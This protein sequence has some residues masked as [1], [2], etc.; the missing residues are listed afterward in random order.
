MY[1][2]S[3]LLATKTRLPRIA[4]E[5][6][7]RPRL[8]QRLSAALQGKLTLIVA[9]AGF[10]K[11]TL[12]AA[13]LKRTLATDVPMRS[14]WVSLDPGDDQPEQFWAYVFNA[15]EHVVPGCTDG[16]ADALRAPSQPPLEF[17]LT[18]LLNVLLNE[19]RPL[20]LVLDDFHVV[21]N[22]AVLRSVVFLLDHL[23][24]SMHVLLLSRHEPD[25]P[26]AR[27]RANRLVTEIGMDE[28]RCTSEEAR[29]VLDHAVGRTLD[30][31]L[32]SELNLRTEGWLAGL[33]LLALSM[34][35][36]RET[37]AL[38]D[39]MRGSQKFVFSYVMD[40]VMRQQ[41][42]DVQLF[43][44]STS[45]L[46]R[47]CAPLCDAVV[48]VNGSQDMLERIEKSLLF[49]IPMDEVRS[50]YRYHALFRDAL[51]KLQQQQ[52]QQATLELHR[53]A[54]DWFA[55]AG[56]VISAV[57]HAELAQDWSRAAE[58]LAAV[59]LAD[60]MSP[61]FAAA[62]LTGFEKFPPDVIYDYPAL[63]LP[64]INL[65]SFNRPDLKTDAWLRGLA[66]RVSA[67]A[68]LAPDQQRQLLGYLAAQRATIAGTF[69][70]APLARS[71]ARDAHHLAPDHV[72]ER[73]LAVAAE[74]TAALIDGDLVAAHDL[75]LDAATM[76]EKA[77]QTITALNLRSIAGMYLIRQGRLEDAWTTLMDALGAVVRPHDPPFA[78]AAFNYAMQAFTLLQRN[79]LD[80]ALEM[81]EQGVTMA[82]QA[83]FRVAVEQSVSLLAPIHLARGAYP[84]AQAALDTAAKLPLHQDNRFT[85]AMWHTPVQVRLWLDTGQVSRA[86]LHVDQLLAR[87]RQASAFGRAFE[88]IAH[89]RVLLAAE[90]PD[91]ALSRIRELLADARRQRRG[92]HELELTIL[93]ARTLHILGFDAAA[94]DA[95][96]RA[97]QRGAP[98]RFARP[99]L[100]EGPA[101]E[102]LLLRLRSQPRVPAH[103]PFVRHLHSQVSPVASINPTPAPAQR[104]EHHVDQ[105]PLSSREV[106]VLT[107]L[108]R[109]QT[110]DD[111]A[112]RLMI[113]IPTVKSHVGNI[114][115]KL[116]ARNRTQAVARA[117]AL[118]LLSSDL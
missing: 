12:A 85:L 91:R 86:K 98:E 43:L 38:L 100:D 11:T 19:Q 69:G 89:V 44:V 74:S 52:G 62:L 54:S 97:V 83:G 61:T 5:L 106:E 53:R 31:A 95:F 22:P 14:A 28:L 96:R 82:E 24:P 17:V 10:G 116:E 87:P 107:L 16:A 36:R 35:G 73:I 47:L 7:E 21:S 105:N 9:P 108:A 41:P 101:L 90:Q 42:E 29:D 33:Q 104:R 15:L 23:P 102:P 109:G 118:G 88:D 64:Y 78:L 76:A 6:V 117:R 92:E 65:L 80:Q 20:T 46:D 49:L 32:I 48:G 30:S 39:D 56:D 115:A 99:F 27:L 103:E 93:E 67:S 58:L 50:W 3:H 66:E 40:E 8:D 13:W 60:L 2:T 112:R 57:E 63:W 77:D 4:A 75:V 34:Q 51:Q 79:Q 26:L 18:S 45:I 94:L 72:F 110:N 113:S 25:L 55:Q 37:Q 71:L 70:N 81:A 84:Q 68:D 114:L 59:P 1:D 111:I